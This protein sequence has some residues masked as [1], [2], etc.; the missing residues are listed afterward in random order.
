MEN[1]SIKTPPP[2]GIL[3]APIIVHVQKL[4]QEL[5]IIAEQIPKRDKLGLHA[6]IEKT[7]IKTLSLCIQASLASKGDKF[8]L[9]RDIRVLIETMK[10]LIRVSH[11]LLI[12][13]QK[14]YISL[15]SKLQEISKMANGW[16]RY[17]TNNP[18]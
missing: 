7:C 10:Y 4:Y 14:K 18:A 17:A 11:E 3:V 8:S 6:E 2:N 9:I 15:E 13:N 1:T 12:I 16:E 5:Y